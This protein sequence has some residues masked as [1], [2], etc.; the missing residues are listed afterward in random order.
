MNLINRMRLIKGAQWIAL[1]KTW[2]FN[3]RTFNLNSFFKKFKGIAF[4]DYSKLNPT[5][6][7]LI[8]NQY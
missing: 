5:P 2:R 1:L 6:L 3:Q 4:V 8:Q 7:A